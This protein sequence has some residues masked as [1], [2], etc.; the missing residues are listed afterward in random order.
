MSVE[1]QRAEAR[2]ADDS[3]ARLADLRA[4][5]AA[6]GLAGFIV[7]KADQHQGEYVAPRAERLAWLT[8][9]TGSAGL[10]IVLAD[11]AAIF[12]DGRYTLQARE[13]VDTCAF[14]PLH[15]LETPA[16]DWLAANLG[17]GDRFGYDPW[18]HTPNEVVKLRAACERA[19][20][21]LVPCEENPLDEVWRDQ[22][23][24]P[25]AP[26][27]PHEVR[28]AG[29]ESADKRRELAAELA[30]DGIAAAVLGAPDSIAW[31]LNV[32]G[33]DIPHTPVALCFA[34]L[35]GDGRVD[36][37]IDRGK[38]TPGV[39]AHLGAG[40]AVR[41]P[42]EFGP[43]LDALGES[44]ARVR[45]DP[46]TAASWIFERLKAAGATIAPGADP[47]A[48]A[49]ARKNPVE[50]R[51]A[52]AAHLRDGTALTRFLAWLA[53]EA[54]K[55][56][57]TEIAAAG[58][59]EAYRREMAMFHGPSFP[60]ISGAGPHG[61]IVHYRV[62][63]ATS[64]RLTPGELYLID[65]G[66]QYLDGTTDVTRTMFIAGNGPPGEEVRDRF[67]RV[68]KGHIAVA[69]AR[70]PEGTTG[71]QLDTLARTHLWEAGLDYDHGTGHGVGSFL[72]VHEGPQ[73]MAKIGSDT[74]L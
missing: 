45:A 36:L 22:P 61:A 29:K 20:A 71:R 23:A 3:A 64:R 6:R 66:G 2:T 56:E 27:V 74:A 1:T 35:Q 18:L 72:G 11:R 43:A 38:V 40:V 50:L 62:S 19:G 8:G 13:Q 10:A 49:K 25:L 51:G 54:P 17:A 53:R 42:D 28:F 46:A 44:A 33:G 41:D 15:A 21:E 59:L 30:A 26:M 65:S 34:I 47:C 58:R 52:F 39:E 32:R 9:F 5:L 60:T 31:L 68:L 55:G 48:L 70:F 4:E 37:F 67:T 12:V 73:R 7:A 14:T 63:E 24:A 69:T 57:L 16:S